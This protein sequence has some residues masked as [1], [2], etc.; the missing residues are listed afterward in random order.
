MLPLFR[1]ISIPA[2]NQLSSNDLNLSFKIIEIYFALKNVSKG[3]ANITIIPKMTLSN[4][5]LINL[6]LVVYRKI[7]MVV[8]IFTDVQVIIAEVRNI[9]SNVNI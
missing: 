8:T 7:S 3:I 4:D 6:F 2:F 1:N 5:R 9:V